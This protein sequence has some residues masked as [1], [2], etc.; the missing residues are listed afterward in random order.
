MTSTALFSL[1][2]LEAAAAVV[3]SVVPQ[4]PQYAWPLL[5]ARVGAEVWIKRQTLR[6]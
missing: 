1:A 5:A 3:S 6:V 4:T 2:E